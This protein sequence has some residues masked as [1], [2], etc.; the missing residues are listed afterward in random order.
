MSSSAIAV[1]DGGANLPE[2]DTAPAADAATRAIAA[3]RQ[4][5]TDGVQRRTKT[6]NGPAPYPPRTRRSPRTA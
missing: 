2:P 3:I 1:Y 4:F 6:V 5:S